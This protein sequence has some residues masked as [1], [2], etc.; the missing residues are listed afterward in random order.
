VPWKSNGR[1]MIARKYFST[2]T[3]P[4]AQ[5]TL[6]SKNFELR[7]GVSARDPARDIGQTSQA[8]LKP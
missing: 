5:S 2:S 4:Q 8:P 3:Q 6:G 1:T 7:D